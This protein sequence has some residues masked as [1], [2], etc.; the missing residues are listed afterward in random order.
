M[1]LLVTEGGC[2]EQA[3]VVPNSALRTMKIRD[4]HLEV[5]ASAP[6]HEH[7]ELDDAS[8]QFPYLYGKLVALKSWRPFV[9]NTWVLFPGVDATQI[10]LLPPL[11]VAVGETS[12]PP[13]KALNIRLRGVGALDGYLDLRSASFDAGEASGTIEAVRPPILSLAAGRRLA[14]DVRRLDQLTVY[15]Q[16]SNPR[17]AIIIVVSILVPLGL[18][19]GI[20][21]A[22]IDS[23]CRQHQPCFFFASPPT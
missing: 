21:A 17:A 19:V 1:L 9:P 8:L 16:K 23:Y 5:E 4:Q 7:L 18:T 6:F 20:T 14:L 3:I 11:P 15:H 10:S 22:L 13:G 2:I 12:S